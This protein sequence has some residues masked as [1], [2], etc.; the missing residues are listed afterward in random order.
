MITYEELAQKIM[1]MSTYDKQA[2]IMVEESTGTKLPLH[3]L[4]MRYDPSGETLVN[5]YLTVLN[6]SSNI[7]SRI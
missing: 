6:K 4:V 5:I 2:P 7:R 3:T 1:S